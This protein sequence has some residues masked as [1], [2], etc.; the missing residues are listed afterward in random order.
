[1]LGTQKSHARLF[2][3]SDL[4][5][6]IAENHLLRAIDRFVDLGGVRVELRGFDSRTGRPSID[7]ELIL[8]ML[9]IGYVMG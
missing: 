9:I 5:A 4:E 1:M 3:E 2:Y 6:H 7:P 8:R